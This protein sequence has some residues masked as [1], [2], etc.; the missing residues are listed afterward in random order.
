MRLFQIMFALPAL[1]SVCIVARGQ[2]VIALRHTVR[3]EA[4]AT[5]V[6]LADVADLAGPRA[7]SLAEVQIVRDIGAEPA[8]GGWAT[9]DAE[10]VRAAVEERG[11]I[12]WGNLVIRG[13]ACSVRRV[14]PVAPE[15]VRVAA[16]EE[17]APATPVPGSIRIAVSEKLGAELGSVFGVS[18]SDV[19]LKFDESD[20]GVL[21]TLCGGLVLDIQ[22]GGAGDRIPVHIRG[23]RD[24]ALAVNAVIRAEVELR[25]DVAVATA[26]LKRDQTLGLDDFAVESRWVPSS[27]RWLDP[28][29]GVG[30]AV[31]QRIGAGEI[32]TVDD[33]RSPV[34]AERGELVTLHCVAGTVVLKTTCRAL[35]DARTGELAKFETLE[36]DRRQRRVIL[37]R[38]NG[39]GVA[40]AS[41]GGVTEAAGVVS[42]AG[43]G[44]GR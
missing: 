1:A 30:Q 39:P 26:A 38:M 5:A 16:S 29:R 20:R 3:L 9:I 36:P 33:V 42:G 15:A 31:K 14:T 21:D 37:A 23:Y 41:V 10:R 4:T 24:G 32:I 43:S 17:P 34:A 25:R 35:Q 22:T 11:E 40:V 2:D 19:R 13:E 44:G 28:G 27:V 12:D 7:E 18:A 8:P 6:R